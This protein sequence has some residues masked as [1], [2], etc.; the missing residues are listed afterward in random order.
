MRGR[1]DEQPHDMRHD[2]ADEADQTAD[3][4]LCGAD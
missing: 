3:G 4:D 2:H 1:P